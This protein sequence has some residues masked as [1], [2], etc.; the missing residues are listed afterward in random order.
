MQNNMLMYRKY[1]IFMEQ[2]VVW[3]IKERWKSLILKGKCF[4]SH[5]AF[6]PRGNCVN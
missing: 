3:S 5:F 6:K 4:E 2:D 1:N